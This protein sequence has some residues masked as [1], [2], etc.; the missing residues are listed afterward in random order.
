MFEI[1]MIFIIAVIANS[2]DF[3]GTSFIGRPLVTS[4]LVGLVMGDLTNALII[5]A[6]LELIFMGLMGVGATVP[7]DEVSGGILATAFALKMGSG[8]EVALTLALPIA[9]LG[10]VVK[11]FLYVVVIPAMSQKADQLCEKGEITKAANMHIWASLTRILSMSV[12]IAVSYAVGSGA[13]EALVNAIPQFIVD[14]MGVATG[15][16][17]AVGFAMLL[18]MTFSKKV[19]PFFFLGFV[20]SA[21]LH[22]DML[23]IAFVGGIFG[24]VMFLI[25]TEMEKNTVKAEVGSDDD[26]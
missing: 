26:F 13:V 14:G 8:I 3:T 12:L 23:A 22:M 10:L 9:T 16:L 24:Y 21:Y 17:P 18:G 20:L 11:N 5:G 19:A 7:P 15:L 2:Q 25:L 1:L 6:S 4:M